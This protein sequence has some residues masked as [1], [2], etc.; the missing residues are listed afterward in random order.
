MLITRQRTTGALLL[1]SAML[2]CGGLA[3]AAFGENPC[4]DKA[5]AAAAKVKKCNLCDLLFGKHPC[6]VCAKKA[7][8]PCAAS[9]SPCPSDGKMTADLPP[10][11]VAGECYA[12]ALIPATYKTV[13][14]RHLTQEASER[15]EIVPAEFKWVEDRI[16]VKEASTQLEAVPAEYKWQEKTI[17][18]KPAHTGWVMQSVADCVLPDK[19]SLKAEAFCQVFCLRT[20]PPVYKTIRTQCLVTPASVRQIAIAAE[21][22]TVRRQVVASA[23][24]TRKVCIPAEYENIDRT[25]LVCPER[26]KWAHIV[27]EDKLTS[28]TVNQ[29]K[30]ALLVSGFKPGPLNGKF[31]QEDRVALNAFQQKS[32]LGVGQLSYETLKQ[33]GVSLQ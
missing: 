15:I 17:E 10:N 11:A 32:G 28:D 19:S 3:S 1:C 27:C 20:T 9:A 8:P 18:V 7:A 5:P 21:Y 6:G 13:T 14:E 29:V 24:T 22:Q 30:S 25:V 12:K 26:V 2:V 16:T 4:A 23:A 33:L 31:S